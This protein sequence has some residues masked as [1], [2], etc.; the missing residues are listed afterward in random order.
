MCP[1]CFLGYFLV[2]AFI[3]QHWLC[4]S[5]CDMLWCLQILSMEALSDLRGCVKM[6][7]AEHPHAASNMFCIP[8]I[9][10]GCK[11]DEVSLSKKKIFSFFLEGV[12]RYSVWTTYKFSNSEAGS[13]RSCFDYFPSPVRDCSAPSAHQFHCMWT[14]GRK[15]KV[16]SS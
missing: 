10:V 2:V 3:L 4:T 1:G 11:F 7:A 12:G 15:N 5:V 8:S 6:F 13:V 14:E 16:K 9:A